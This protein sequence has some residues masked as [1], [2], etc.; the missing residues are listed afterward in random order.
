M[1]TTVEV[2]PLARDP[3]FPCNLLRFPFTSLLLDCA[4]EVVKHDGGI[5]HILPPALLQLDLTAIDAIIISNCYNTTALPYITEHLGF[6]GKI[7]ATGPT[8]EFGRILMEGLIDAFA[9]DSAT[10]Q[11]HLCVQMG[12]RL[13]PLYTLHDI[14]SCLDKVEQV[15]YRQVLPLTKEITLRTHSSGYCLGGTIWTVSSVNG[16]V[17]YLAASS[18]SSVGHST[19]IDV[20]AFEKSDLAIVCQTGPVT[21]SQPLVS[22]IDHMV[23][24][25]AHTIE[26]R[27]NVLFPISPAGMLFELI[28]YL[29]KFLRAAGFVETPM[30]VVSPVAERALQL[31]TIQGEWMSTDLQSSLYQGRQPLLHGFLLEEK[32]L[33]HHSEPE[34]IFKYRGPYIVFCSS[35]TLAGGPI[36][37]FLSLWGNDPRN[38]LIQTETL[39]IPAINNT[40]LSTYNIRVLECRMETRLDMSE[41]SQKLQSKRVIVPLPAGQTAAKWGL[42]IDT[43]PDTDYIPLPPE[44]TAQITLPGDFVKQTIDEKD[45]RTILP[46]S[47]SS[48]PSTSISTS[49]TLYTTA[50][51]PNRIRKSLPVTDFA[52]GL[53]NHLP[54]LAKVLSSTFGPST[55]LS[56]PPNT[57]ILE[58]SR[59][60][61]HIRVV[62]DEQTVI[63]ETSQ[64][65][66]LR[67]VEDALKQL[68]DTVAAATSSSSN[69]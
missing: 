50:D 61:V 49:A 55:I 19:V 17:V 3:R 35:A 1:G 63:I 38:L 28:S 58:F 57:T 33:F 39:N 46:A 11:V 16:K 47:S 67:R 44:E 53:A 36:A 48:T 60:S 21:I 51:R 69:P 41:L 66:D 37:E 24:Q 20:A 65:V 54:D 23:R 30:H 2:T 62:S 59:S 7:F 14:K 64:I 29:S 31:A 26:Q 8:I 27:G 9:R 22:T 4:L 6:K 42:D 5:R 40:P 45:I 43:R 12:A 15:Y 56:E 18:N 68:Q 13:H 25:V 34:G 52:G 10:G 32:M